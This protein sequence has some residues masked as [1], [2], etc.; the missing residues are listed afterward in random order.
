MRAKSLVLLVIAL[1][2]GM[3]AAVGVSKAI[4]DKPPEPRPRRPLA[5]IF[6]AVKDLP[7]AQ[8][9]SADSVKLEKWPKQSASRRCVGQPQTNWKENTPTSR[10]LLANRS[11]LASWPTLARV[12]PRRFRLA[13]AC[14]IFRDRLATSSLETTST[15]SEHFNTGGR[16]SVAETR[17]VMRNVQ[18]FG[19]NGVTTRDSDN[20]Q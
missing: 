18:V 1:G 13:I 14:S 4:M 9:I 19:I 2:C 10:F 11:W 20:S 5:E 8:K 16:G 12:F 15:F 6:V 3:I 17:T 7:H